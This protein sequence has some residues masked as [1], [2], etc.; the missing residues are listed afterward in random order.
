M[1]CSFFIL[2]ILLDFTRILT[3]LLRIFPPSIGLI[4]LSLA[5]L[6]SPL[7][8][9]DIFLTHSHIL[10]NNFADSLLGKDNQTVKSENCC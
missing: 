10:I 5:Q 9:S 2:S 4:I 1:T 6:D 3:L 7:D 8:F